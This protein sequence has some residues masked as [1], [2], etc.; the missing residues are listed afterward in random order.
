MRTH[1][2]FMQLRHRSTSPS[3]MEFLVALR[4]ANAACVAED[5]R[6]ARRWRERI[7]G[8]TAKRIE[9]AR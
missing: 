4:D 2:S 8:R 9:Q 1:W 7:A 5:A 3:G 6:L